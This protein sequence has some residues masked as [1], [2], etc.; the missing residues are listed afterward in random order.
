[1]AKPKQ[2]RLIESKLS[3]LQDLAQ[4]YAEVRNQRAAL[5]PEEVRLKGELLAAMKKHKLKDYVYE[6]IEIH[7]VTESE[8]VKVKV[9]KPKGEEDDEE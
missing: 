8:T 1:M 3:D 6:D 9:H 4:E 5:T 7:V 2:A